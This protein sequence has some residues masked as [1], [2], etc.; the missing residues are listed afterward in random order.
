MFPVAAK[1]SAVKSMEAKKKYVI[2]N[3]SEGELETFK[4]YFILKNHLKDVIAGIKIAVDEIDADKAYIYL[5]KNYYEEIA[6]LIKDI[7]GEEIVVVQKKGGYVGGEET[8]VIEAIEGNEPWPRI[9]PPFPAEKGLFDYPTLINN[10][11]TFYCIAK[12]SRDDYKNERFFSVSGDAPSKG[13]FVDDKNIS[14][15]DLLEKTKNIPDF[16]FFVQIGGGAGGLIFLKEE[17]AKKTFDC[18]GSVVIYNRETDPYQLMG[19]W[20]DFLM[21]GNCD[22][23]TP[24]RE[25]LYRIK[26]MVDSKDFS[27]IDDIFFVMQKTSLCPLGRVAV[28]PF[29][30]LLNKI[31]LK[32]GSN[33]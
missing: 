31:V 25:G 15:L 18:L 29:Y 5:N 19:K 32:D 6:P 26:E 13:V 9:K 4:D 24:C 3:A 11:E 16:D 21:D 8:S 33:N 28:N 17:L 23:C 12:I 2:C 27:Y 10:V 14:V 22:K 30:S 20:V 1:W 7:V